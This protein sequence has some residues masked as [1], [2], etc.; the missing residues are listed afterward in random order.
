[1]TFQEYLNQKGISKYRLSILSGVPKATISD[2]ASGKS[3]LPKCSAKT[4]F[5]LSKAL[6]CSMEDLL[7]LEVAHDDGLPTGKEYL[8]KDLPPYLAH[9]IK[10]MLAAWE[11]MD[12]GER[13]STADMDW[14]EL[15]AD[16][17]CAE[18][19]QLITSE[20]AWH[21]REKYLRMERRK[22]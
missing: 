21:L 17:N 2:I 11:V 15:N 18:V 7:E 5:L 13:S 22:F 10:Q 3:E 16:I 9:S 12:R 19:D 1:M 8:E 4:V 14:C 6:G 20:Q